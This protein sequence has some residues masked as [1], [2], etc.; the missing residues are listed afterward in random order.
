MKIL[1]GS[2]IQE[3]NT[4]SPVR[5]TMDDFYRHHWL[6]GE[7]VRGI[8]TENELKGFLV[9]AG[10]EGVETFPVLSANAVSSGMLTADA[11]REMKEVLRRRLQEAVREAGTVGG[12]YFALH[13]AMVAEG[14]DDTEAELAG[15]IRQTA[16]PGVPLVVSLDLHANVTRALV[17]QVDG[18]VG[19]RTY[20][21]TDFYETGKRAARLLFAAVRGE[22]RPFVTMRKL[23]LIVPAENSQSTSGPFAELWMEA[24]KGEA[25]GDSLVTS[26][27]PMQ[28][29][30]DIEEAGSTVV[31]VG[32]ARRREDGVREAERLA[33]LFWSLRKAFDVRLLSLEEMI[34]LVRSC[35]RAE[36]EGPLV[37]SDSA[38]SPSA[39]STGDSNAVLKALLESGLHRSRSCLLTMVDPAAVDR[40]VEAGVGQELI[41][42]LGYGCEG[43]AGSRFGLPLEV[44][45]RVRRIGDGRFTLQ[46][47]YAKNTEAFMG[48]CAVFETGRVSVLL[49]ER[50]TFSGDPAM[51]RSMGLEPLDADVVVVKSANQFR[52]DYEKLAR[53]ISILDTPGYSSANLKSLPFRR[54]NRP[55]YPLDDPEDWT[56]H[57]LYGRTKQC[58]EEETDGLF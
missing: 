20:P 11:F 24:E 28:P 14:T 6:M 16:G 8:T 41:L 34:G 4:F 42:P 38:D 43:S 58:K 1:I 2:I 7:A 12:V 36:K 10:E 29:W 30:L 44:Q 22:I 45:G 17:R 5:S 37:F 18:L 23:P 40:A 15:I 55:F 25:R 27:F 50:P 21:H 46:G 31:V 52:A 13:G 33:D 26:L 48:R 3:S 53:S 57:P 51:Y 39:G 9:A 19:F 35:S 56:E 54:V 49:T 47:G 32:D